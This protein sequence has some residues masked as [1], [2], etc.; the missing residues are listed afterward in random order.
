MSDADEFEA[1]LPDGKVVDDPAVFTKAWKEFAALVSEEFDELEL[2][3]VAFNPGVLY[4]FGPV[5]KQWHS[6]ELPMAFHKALN[7]RIQ[8]LRRLREFF[9]EM[10][11]ISKQA[12]FY[13]EVKD[14]IVKVGKR[15]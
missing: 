1:T 8:E 12:G 2:K 11:E 6:L 4:A 14:V 5:V 7:D 10:V 15:E 3:A 9:F 13:T